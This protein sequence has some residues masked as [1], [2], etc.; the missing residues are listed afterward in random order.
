MTGVSGEVNRPRVKDKLWKP[1]RKAA[2]RDDKSSVQ[3]PKSWLQEA[4]I[5][6]K[7]DNLGFIK[8]NTCKGSKLI[9]YIK[10]HNT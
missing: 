9:K 6:Q 8:D 5:D 7:S 3:T 4:A 2:L 1:P 10:I